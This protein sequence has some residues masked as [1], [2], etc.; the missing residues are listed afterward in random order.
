MKNIAICIS[1]KHLI[2]ISWRLMSIICHTLAFFYVISIFLISDVDYPCAHY[3]LWILSLC[4]LLFVITPVCTTFCGNHP[5]EHY[6]L[7]RLPLCALL[8]MDVTPVCTTFC[9]CYPCVHY[10]LWLPL[11]ALL[12]VDITPVHY[13]Y[14]SMT[15]YDI[16]MGNTHIHCFW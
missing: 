14:V 5:C 15:H 2:I 7:W 6:V 9:G 16:N 3:V 13:F 10:V 4:A 1:L 8:F 11:C 12:F